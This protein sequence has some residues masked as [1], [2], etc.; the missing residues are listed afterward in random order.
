MKKN[1]YIQNLQCLGCGNIF[2]IPRKLNK[3]REKHHIKHLYCV[4]CNG[5]MPHMEI[6]EDD[7][8]DFSKEIMRQ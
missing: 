3:K 8:Y 1:I 5:E 7:L 2:P 4:K 6:E